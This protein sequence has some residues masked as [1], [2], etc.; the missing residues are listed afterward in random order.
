MPVGVIQQ[1]MFKLRIVHNLTNSII[2]MMISNT[3]INNQMKIF[4]KN[5]NIL[6]IQLS[7]S[8]HKQNSLLKNKH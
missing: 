5:M 1:F 3:C 7:T 4:F 8:K 6:I 2:N